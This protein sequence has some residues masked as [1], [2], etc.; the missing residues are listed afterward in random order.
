[1]RHRRSCR[2]Q[3]VQ[4]PIIHLLDHVRSSPGLCSLHLDLRHNLLNLLTPHHEVPKS[5]RSLVLQSPDLYHLSNLGLRYHY[6][7]DLQLTNRLGLRLL[8]TLDMHCLITLHPHSL[9]LLNLHRNLLSVLHPLSLHSL[10]NLSRTMHPLKRM[11][12]LQ[13]KL[14]PNGQS[15]KRR[16]LASTQLDSSYLYRRILEG[17]SHPNRS[18]R[19]WIGGP[20]T[21]SC[22]RTSRQWGLGWIGSDLQRPC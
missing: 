5:M 4:P 21:R 3:Q 8:N 9:V 22:V 12:R 13:E 14:R 11:P 18:M 17:R 19:Y 6:F 2:D 10:C 20:P 1:M 16:L 7:L 15:R